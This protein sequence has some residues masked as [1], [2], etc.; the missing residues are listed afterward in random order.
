[1]RRWMG[2]TCVFIGPW[3]TSCGVAS[4][5]ASSLQSTP[6][7]DVVKVYGAWSYCEPPAS[8]SLSR[9]NAGVLKSESLRA[10]SGARYDLLIVPGYTPA[11]AEKPLARVDPI[12]AARLD[13]AVA[14]YRE[15]K[16]PLVFVSGG[17]VRPLDT[18]YTEALTAKAYLIERG[19]SE[20]AIVVEP[21]ARHSTTNLRNAGR[22]MLKYH[23][24]TALVVTSADQAFYFANGRVSSLELRSRT[25]LGYMVGDVKGKSTTT[26]E[27]APSDDVLRRGPDPLDP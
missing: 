4:C 15:G 12:A 1:M 6:A 25:E 11:D 8:V 24:R 3:L 26:V 18:P 22:F 9:E 17:N 13:E 2:R 20:N 5:G 10:R 14:L 21:C 27:F 19:L 23:L 16:A 7:A